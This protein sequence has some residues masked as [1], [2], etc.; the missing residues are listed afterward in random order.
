MGGN[1]L[2]SI[3][4]DP[5]E[6]KATDE[7][8]GQVDEAPIARLKRWIEVDN[9][10]DDLPDD[11]LGEIALLVHQE[12]EIDE[13]S[14]HDWLERSAAAL[15][16]AAQVAGE[17]SSPWP[18]A[19]NVI[20][21]LVTSAAIQFAARAYPAIVKGRDVVKGI[22]IGSD[23]GTPMPAA[24]QAPAPGMMQPPPAM[25]PGPGAFPPPS[26]PPAAMP[27][28]PMGGQG[29]PMPGGMDGAMTPGPGGAPGTDQLAAMMGSASQLPQ[30]QWAVAPGEKR[31]RAERVAQH[32]SYQILDEMEGWEE[33]TDKL[34]HI[35]S[36]V[37]CEFR[38]TWFDR[39][40][41]LNCSQRVSAEHVV[42]NY[43]APSMERAPRVTEIQMVYPQEIR[44]N[45][46]AGLWLD[47]EYGRAYVGEGVA[48]QD[49]DAPHTVLEQHRWLDLDDDGYAEPYIVTLHKETRKVVRISARYDEDGIKEKD[50]KIIKIEPVHYY[51]K[52][53]FLPSTD[54]GIYGMGFGKLLYPINESVNTALNQLFDAGTLANSGGG[55]I[56][57]SVAPPGG[58]VRFK[59]GE[60][61]PLRTAGTSLRE[62]L[63]PLDAP[64]PNPTSFALLGF[65]VEAGREIA[66]V[67]DVLTGDVNASTM[68]PTTLLALIEQGLQVFTAVYKRVHRALKSEFK[69][70]YRL[71]RVYGAERS[72]YRY[73]DEWREVTRQ[74]Y[75]KAAGVAPVSDPSMVSNMQRAARAQFLLNFA[76]DPLLDR[77]K[78]YDRVFDEVGIEDYESLYNTEKPQPPPDFVLKAD[79]QA[80]RARE[81]DLKEKIAEA[82]QRRL[83][84]ESGAKVLLQRAQALKAL[85]EADAA[86]GNQDLQWELGQMQ[87][88]QQEF[89]ALSR[90]I[91]STIEAR[92]PSKPTPKEPEP[93][94]DDGAPIPGAQR[95]EDGNWYVG[96]EQN[97]FFRVEM[98]P[99]GG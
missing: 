45:V 52:Y 9:I 20:Y 3:A 96:D 53:D 87:M 47:Q 66:S 75:E 84:A 29:G 16:L 22:V 7:T 23:R 78:I 30:Q 72:E 59:P 43:K 68:Q 42:I 79:E 90:G 28:G 31:A 21:P 33:D 24:F 63:V 60:W 14:R 98:P 10:A 11:K 62:A 32:M 25:A 82:E 70:L 13:D 4:G 6:T 76:Q 40:L 92:R 35:M 85:A 51:T 5:V 36:I 91:E 95:A 73:G 71:N 93:E 12:Y 39:S 80:L 15:K 69:K 55:W 58:V 41:R 54:G 50:G 49:D 67:K 34:L 44:E 94:D 46:L 99:S 64:G 65:L 97:G 18:S 77:R 57:Q 56:G 81:L 1:A 83:D 37:G 89:E 17:K 88:L 26:A 27:T 19:S 8:S 61:K 48:P 2:A 86:A 38:K 74:D